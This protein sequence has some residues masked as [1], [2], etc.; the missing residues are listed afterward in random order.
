MSE[1]PHLSQIF[2]RLKRGC[3]LGPDDEP[4]Y[5]ALLSRYAEYAAYFAPLGLNLLRHEREFF[6]FEPDN[7]DSVPDTL[8][9]IAV[10]SY[11]L[12]DH[13]ANQGRPVEEFIFAR[14][15]I[16]SALPHFSLDRYSAL[17]RQV[18][19]HDMKGLE[20]ILRHMERIGWVR[21]VAG[22]E[23]RFLRPFHRVLSKCLELAETAATPAAT[24]EPKA[25]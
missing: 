14:N 9:R 3:H 10:F 22:D 12:V 24:P 23:F 16:L 6:Y 19:V 17:L 15:F 25:P 11:I 21:W 5:S 13:A 2:D 8:P 20:N 7:P 1:L 18:E 4:H